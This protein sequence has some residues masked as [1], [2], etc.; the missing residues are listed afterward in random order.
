MIWN[1]FV[2]SWKFKLLWWT[3]AWLWDFFKKKKKKIRNKSLPWFMHEKANK[4]LCLQTWLSYSLKCHNPCRC[5]I[6]VYFCQ[7][8]LC[9]ILL[10][11]VSCLNICSF[12]NCTQ[13][14]MLFIIC[15]GVILTSLLRA[16]CDQFHWFHSEQDKQSLLRFSFLSMWKE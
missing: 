13:Q 6:P 12:T 1:L 14:G 5:R 10:H 11:L 15:E 8:C 4:I 16:H 7:T 3:A 9:G 2:A